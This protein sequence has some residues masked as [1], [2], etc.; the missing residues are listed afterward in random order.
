MAADLGQVQLGRGRDGLVGGDVAGQAPARVRLVV[1]GA[2][3]QAM[4]QRAT[5]EGVGEGFFSLKAQAVARHDPAD[6]LDDIAGDH[7]QERLAPTRRDGG[8]DVGDARCLV[9][10]ETATRLATEHWCVRRGWWAEA[11]PWFVSR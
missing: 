4:G 10:R 9:G 5:P 6:A 1:R 3:R 2:H 7:G 8:Q 11:T